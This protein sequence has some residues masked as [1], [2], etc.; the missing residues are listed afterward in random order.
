[1]FVLQVLKNGEGTLIVYRR[2]KTNTCASEYIPCEYCMGFF[3]ESHLWEHAKGCY[4][5]K[6]E[7]ESSKNYVRN[8]RIMIMP[9]IIHKEG[10][11]N[12]LDDVISRMKETKENP[13]LKEVCLEDELIREFG[14]CLLERLGTSEEQRRKDEDNIRT[15]LRCVARL[16]K[17]LNDKKIVNQPLTNYINAREFNAVVTAVKDL[18]RESNSPQL[19]I[20]LGNYLKQITLLKASL[21][22]QEENDRKKIEANNFLEM[23]AAHWLSRVKSV[24]NRTQQLR[25]IN[26]SND[27]PSR[28]DL[29]EL[30]NYITKEMKVHMKNK[31]P[32]YDQYVKMAQLLIVRIALFNKR[33][34]S[35]VD[36]LTV[37]DYEKRIRGSEIGNSEIIQ[38]LEFSERA[39]LKRYLY[40]AQKKV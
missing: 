24:A 9:F 31:T 7:V 30:K 10:E 6:N 37:I 17:K 1:M 21:A 40:I 8:G 39:L 20:S 22:I 25:A 14:M 23:H 27:I 13:G 18:Y 3:H 32:T 28:E 2:P 19:A 34:I 5:R 29:V 16:L 12:K 35:E 33:R 15:K 4:F 11:T 36:E 26:S 38:S